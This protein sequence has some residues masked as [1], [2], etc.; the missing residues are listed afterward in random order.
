MCSTFWGS[1]VKIMFG[2]PADGAVLMK[3]VRY[4]KQV[5]A[6]IIKLTR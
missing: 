6:S 5:I 1:I 3:D 2:I 4:I